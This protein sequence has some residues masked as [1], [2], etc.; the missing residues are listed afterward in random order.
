MGSTGTVSN[1][2]LDFG[3]KNL[4]GFDDLYGK[5]VME[6]VEWFNQNSNLSDWN[7]NLSR[8]QY[9]AIRDYVGQ[10]YREINGRQYKVPWEDM[11]GEWKTKISNLYNAIN[12][13][14]LDEGITVDR[15]CNFQVF[16]A[17]E[18]ET[19]SVKQIKDF[20]KQS[21]GFMQND[22]FMSFSTREDGVIVKKNYGVVIKLRVPPSVGAGAYIAPVSPMPS[23]SEFL[24]NNNSVLKYDIGSVRKRKDGIIEVTADWVGRSSAQT[25]SATYQGTLKKNSSAGDKKATNNWFKKFLFND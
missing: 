10:G 7:N 13:F 20:L 5:S 1:D 6:N 11:S 23:E 9:D 25:I 3:L 16:G 17:K 12:T 24:L 4:F 21:D 22:G 19:L 14:D 8:E 15:A 18:G 2:I